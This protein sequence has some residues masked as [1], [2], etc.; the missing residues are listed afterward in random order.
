MSF[1]VSRSFFIR[2]NLTSLRSTEWPVYA[3]RPFAG[4][5]HV[6]AY[7]ARY[8]HRVAISNH[9]LL[10]IDENGVTFSWRDYRDGALTKS[11]TLATSRNVRRS[12]VT[13]TFAQ[14][15]LTNASWYEAT[16]ALRIEEAFGPSQLRNYCR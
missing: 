14:I 4:P 2:C 6:L 16:L 7:L 9:R 8:T 1:L 3:K 15:D 5:E 13:T 10:A 12:S 11:M